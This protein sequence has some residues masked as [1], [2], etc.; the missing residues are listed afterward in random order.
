[1]SRF[2]RLVTFQYTGTRTHR[3]G[4][5]V[6]SGQH[7]LDLSA[8]H[9][10]LP[11]D[12]KEMLTRGPSTKAYNVVSTSP[13][14]MHIRVSDVTLKAPLYNP[15]KILCV[16]LNYADHARE[17][18]M[19]I[20]KEPILF[21]KF[22]SAII[23]SGEAIVKP[24]STEEL[25]YEVELAV[26]IGKTGKNIPEDSALLHV[27]GYTVAND[28]SARDWQ[29]RKGGQWLAG[30]TFDTFAPL[31]PCILVNPAWYPEAQVTFDPNNLGI[32][33][34]LNDRVVQNSSTKEFIFNVQQVVAYASRIMT[35]RAGDIILTG[36]PPGVGL[37]HKP[38][39]WMVPGDRVT[40]EIEGIGEISNPIVAE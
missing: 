14:S 10:G 11:K 38:P 27:G 2:L 31:G 8:K 6:G 7:L 12:M 16:G 15:Q 32:R 4:A 30:K 3:V 17:S 20:P 33:C 40:C 22:P 28:V 34:K 9:L 19:P 5:L 36:T 23:G 1:M 18:N 39:L 25:D 37:G 13:P 35:L 21:S 29:L 26:V 24:S